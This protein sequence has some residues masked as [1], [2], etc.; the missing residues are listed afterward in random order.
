MKPFWK[1]HQHLRK[2]QEPRRC[3][4]LIVSVCWREPSGPRRYVSVAANRTP[5]TQ[6]WSAQST[7]SATAVVVLGHT[8]TRGATPVTPSPTKM[9]LVS[10][11]TTT[12]T[13]TCTGRMTRNTTT[14]Q[15]RGDFVPEG[16]IVLQQ[17]AYISF[18]SYFYL[19][20]VLLQSVT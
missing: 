7:K 4:S 10:L 20:H 11:T 19:S 15:S 18:V 14:R 2:P 13:T 3:C 8:D 17:C 9:R 1:H 16:G 5:I 6:N 12:P